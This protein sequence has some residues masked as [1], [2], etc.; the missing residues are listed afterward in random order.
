ML[1]K[2]DALVWSTADHAASMPSSQLVLH[3]NPTRVLSMYMLTAPSCPLPC[4]PPCRLNFYCE[5]LLLPFLAWG[6]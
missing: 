5:Y 4:S 2:S 1:Q 6:I 3:S